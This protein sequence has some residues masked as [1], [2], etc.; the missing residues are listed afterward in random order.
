MRA[1]RALPPLDHHAFRMVAF[2]TGVFALASTTLATQLTLRL[3]LRISAGDQL[4]ARRLEPQTLRAQCLD[5]RAVVTHEQP[6]ALVT[7]EPARE[8]APR[9]RV[10]VV[11]RF[12]DGQQCGSVPERGSDLC[13]LALAVAE[14]VP[15]QG[16]VRLYAE[17]PAQRAR[18][19]ALRFQERG[20]PL[21]GF[22]GALFTI[23]GVSRR[24]DDPLLRGQRGG[25]KPQQGRL[26]CAIRADDTRE[27]ARKGDRERGE[28]WFARRVV[29]EPH[30]AKR[31]GSV[32]YRRRPAILTR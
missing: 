12:V 5:Q 23:D 25:R 15:T 28:E 16:K 4:G 30:I 9:L 22:V 19:L 17:P 11:G 10:D 24:L 2:A 29:A 8:Q 6:N 27:A 1:R 31:N 3:S 26:P 18:V 20:Q 21:W 7:C 13:A 32:G 14:R